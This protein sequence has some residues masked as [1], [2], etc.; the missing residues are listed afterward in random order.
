M[1]YILFFVSFL[2]LLFYSFYHDNHM[3]KNMKICL[4]IILVLIKTKFGYAQIS[5]L[6]TPQTNIEKSLY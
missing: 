3:M 1:F 5:N 2:L 4:S 6:G